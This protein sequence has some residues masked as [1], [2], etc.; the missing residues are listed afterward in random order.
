MSR[1]AGFII[2]LCV[3]S[4]ILV[5]PLLRQ[6]KTST[7]NVPPS[8]S[9]P[10]PKVEFTRPLSEMEELPEGSIVFDLSYLG[11]KGTEDDIQYTSFWGFGR[12]HGSKE[13]TPFIKNVRKAEGD[14]HIVYNRYFGDAEL[15]A[16]KVANRK[17]KVFY[18]DLDQNGKLSENEKLLP[19]FYEEL[20]RNFF[21]TDFMTP[22]F[23]LKPPG[24][25]TFSFRTLLRVEF[26]DSAEPQE[27]WSPA[28]VLQ[29]S[30][31][32][33][34]KPVRLTVFTSGFE[35]SFARFGR[36]QYSIVS[37]DG[38]EPKKVSN[39][40]HMLSSLVSH[41]GVFYQVKFF[42]SNE[43]GKVLKAALIEDTS[44]R[45]KI[46][47]KIDSDNSLKTN[48]EYA[49]ILGKDDNTINFNIVKG[50]SELPVGDYVL[51]RGKLGYGIENNREWSIEFSE[52]PGFAVKHDERS[53]IKLGKPVL[54]VKAIDYNKRYRSN[55]KEQ[56]EFK[57][58][59]KIH[60][61]PEIRGMA[62]ELYGRIQYLD[63]KR[64]LDHPPTIHIL[65]PDGAVFAS[66]T[67]EYG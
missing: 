16:V 10:Q 9:S 42:G 36:C 4:V 64:R 14:V 5:P 23:D 40:R 31:S 13:D 51:S 8:A 21:R 19:V 59:I 38:Y 50:Q 53:V 33:K 54:S 30:A 1:K 67:L 45:G 63:K 62:G 22:D 17:A 65:D 3:L 27:M 28:C 2:I 15:S 11:L 32:I 7:R 47:I 25:G 29:G 60:L 48:L 18:F 58:G 35:G 37:E 12:P 34:N 24:G 44:P 39:S 57:K 43:K 55:V 49:T 52:G 61:E 66:K 41:D 6:K 46:S 56:S 20:S 26:Y